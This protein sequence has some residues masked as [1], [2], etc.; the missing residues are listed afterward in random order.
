M[1]PGVVRS[2]GFATLLPLAKQVQVDQKP[3]PTHA[4]PGSS[5]LARDSSVQMT[6][7]VSVRLSVPWRQ[8][9]Q[10]EAVQKRDMSSS[11][12]ACTLSWPVVPGAPTTRT[13]APFIIHDIDNRLSALARLPA[14][15]FARAP[16]AGLLVS[17][18]SL[19]NG[20]TTISIQSYKRLSLS[21]LPAMDHT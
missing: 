4:P 2:S 15:P 14:A 11:Y 8:D 6:S 10:R 17:V 20:S 7:L 9:K 12:G 5:M 19:H 3:S 18:P 1:V 21:L 13:I 16:G